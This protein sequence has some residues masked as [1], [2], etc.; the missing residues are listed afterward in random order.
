MAH[1]FDY[2]LIVIGSGA[3]GSVA[4]TIAAREGWRVAII[5]EDLFGGDSSNWGD[6][7]TKALL[8]TAHLYASVKRGDRFGLRTTTLGYNY[9]SIRA[10]KEL[11]IKQTGVGNDRK[12]YTEQGITTFQGKAHFLTPHEITVNRRHL[13]ARYFIVATG[14][15][16]AKPSFQHADD[17]TFHSPRTILEM[18]R[19][20]KSLLVVGGGRHAVEIA[21]LMAVFGTEVVIVEAKKHL[22]PD[23]DKEV[24][25]AVATS[26]RRDHGIITLASTHVHSVVREGTEKRV[27]LSR[28]ETKKHLTVSEVLVA[29]SYAPNI[30]L[31]LDN[32]LVKYSEKGIEVD[33]FLRTSTKHIYAAGDVLGN[34]HDTTAT[35]LESRVIAH[36][37][38]GN[39]KVKP[40]YEAMPRVVFTNPEV[41]QVGITQRHARQQKIAMKQVTV[42]LSYVAAGTL[43]DTHD[44]F[45][46]LIVGAHGVILGGTI[47]G[48]RASELIQEISLAVRHQLTATQLAQTPHVFL[49]WSEAIRVA[50]QKLARSG[51]V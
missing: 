14:A 27:T 50:A 45:V 18:L 23:F 47:V 13:S 20:P 37:M 7:P 44:G 8:Q 10:W 43:A 33:Q 5:E 4:A 2:D 3:G 36:N 49:S 42:P 31:G 41:A 35:L 38:L 39:L 11:A 30:D 12:F 1:T 26:L 25:E 21:Q 22:L 32:A 16:W 24:G 40:D 19:P 29:D 51:I 6:V 46:T 48:P 34:F 17:V 9:P 28:G 15:T